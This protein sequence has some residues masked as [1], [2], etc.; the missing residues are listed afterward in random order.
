MAEVFSATLPTKFQDIG[1]AEECITAAVENSTACSKAF[2]RMGL[3]QWSKVSVEVMMDYSG[4]K[5]NIFPQRNNFE[6][7][8]KYL[9][10]AVAL[11]NQNFFAIVDWIELLLHRVEEKSDILLTE[12]FVELLSP[13]FDWTR[14]QMARL[15]F[16]NGCFLFITNK[17]K[18]A[19][20]DCWIRAYETYGSLHFQLV[21]KEARRFRWTSFDKNEILKLLSSSKRSSLKIVKRMINEVGKNSLI[22]KNVQNKS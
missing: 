5:K 11:K 12:V 15:I 10:E 4:Q 17:K 2:H 18:K 14:T 3:F 6:N 9:T 21:F 22:K 1:L 13:N 20:M 19:T 8:L 7:A 16:L